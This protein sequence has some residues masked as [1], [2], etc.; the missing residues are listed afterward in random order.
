[1]RSRL[2]ARTTARV[3]AY[4]VGRWRKGAKVNKRCPTCV[5]TRNISP[6]HKLMSEARLRKNIET[7]TGQDARLRHREAPTEGSRKS[8]NGRET[9]EDNFGRPLDALDEM[10]AGRRGEAVGTKGISERGEGGRRRCE[11][12]G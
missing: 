12:S 1:M 7:L 11:P 5:R 4:E 2:R 9:L 6:L 3:M 8:R 10:S